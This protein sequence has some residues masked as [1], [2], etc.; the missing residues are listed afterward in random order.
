MDPLDEKLSQMMNKSKIDDAM[1]ID[2]DQDLSADKEEVEVKKA[3]APEIPKEPVSKAMT[4]LLELFKKETR[5]SGFYD[6]MEQPLRN[7]VQKFLIENKMLEDHECA[8]R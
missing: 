6:H 4:L 1:T 7:K 2:P 8:R 5:D 3:P